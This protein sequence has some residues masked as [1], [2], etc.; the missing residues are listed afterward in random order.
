M[1][2]SLDIN[3]N[4][5]SLKFYV[6]MIQINKFGREHEQNFYILRLVKPN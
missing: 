2:I 1:V 3:S 5:N 4:R 6:P